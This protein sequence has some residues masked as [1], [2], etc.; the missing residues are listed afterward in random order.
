MLNPPLDDF[1]SLQAVSNDWYSPRP[2]EGNCHIIG[3][4]TAHS[5]LIIIIYW[6]HLMS[7]LILQPERNSVH[8]LGHSPANILMTLEYTIE[9]S[10]ALS[11]IQSAGVSVNDDSLNVCSNPL[12]N[13]KRSDTLVTALVVVPSFNEFIN[14]TSNSQ[15]NM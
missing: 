4:T 6:Y 3:N 11:S 10:H 13:E 12:P 2:M 14:D 15:L 9:L 5:F 1:S 7:P 8:Q